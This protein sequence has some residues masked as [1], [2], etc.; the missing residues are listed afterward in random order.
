[1]SFFRTYLSR[2]IGGTGRFQAF[3]DVNMT[4]AQ[5]QSVGGGFPGEVATLWGQRYQLFQ[6]R[7]GGA[8]TIGQT[9]SLY[10][11]AASRV[12]NLTGASSTYLLVT[13]DT[14][15]AGL[16][17]NKDYPG[18]IGVTAGVFATT[19]AEQRRQIFNNTPAAGASK[20]GIIDPD[21]GALSDGPVNGAP[22]NDPDIIAA[23]D[24]TF[25]YEVVCPWE[26]V[27]ADN[28]NLVTSLVQGIVCSTTI[29]N[30]NFG[31]LQLDGLAMANVDGTTDLVASDYLAQSTT[32]G[33]LVKWAPTTT[34]ATLA[35]LIQGLGVR[36]RIMGAYTNDG[37]G[38]RM[39]QLGL[40]PLF[41]QPVP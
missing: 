33:V 26:M 7:S 6:N 18:Y 2:S 14:H 23:V 38:L 32:P 11:G 21:A 27:P 36:A 39:I 31:V 35:Q 17:G 25:D 9:A 10:F 28:T 19:A 16:A 22:G 30:G 29:A 8:M 24:A 13:D 4:L 5:I 3:S 12:G 15:D 20:V 37:V 41:P 34:A 40:G 1:M